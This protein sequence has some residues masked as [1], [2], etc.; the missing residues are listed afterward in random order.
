MFASH[1]LLMVTKIT[2]TICF[3]MLAYLNIAAQPLPKYIKKIDFYARPVYSRG[4]YPSEVVNV[5]GTVEPN[6]N[7]QPSFQYFLY[8]QTAS[9]KKLKIRSVEIDGVNY[10]VHLKQIASPVI[11]DVKDE[12]GDIT[13]VK[14]TNNSLFQLA[15]LTPASKLKSDRQVHH[16]I[17]I[18]GSVQGKSFSLSTNA[19]ALPALS[20]Q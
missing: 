10:L 18:R 13:L 1:N 7:T 14:K 11:L 15:S 8:L 9:Y 5:D 19:V 3:L 6:E 20:A 4:A 16:S 17:I 2:Y 12:E